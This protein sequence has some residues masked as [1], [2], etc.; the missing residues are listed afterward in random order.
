M[1]KKK[2]SKTPTQADENEQN[3][4]KGDSRCDVCVIEE[5]DGESVD[6]ATDN[7]DS[8]CKRGRDADDNMAQQAEISSSTNID[9]DI[10]RSTQ[11]NIKSYI[12]AETEQSNW[13]DC[14][15][16]RDTGASNSVVS[17]VIVHEESSHD[18]AEQ[19]SGQCDPSW[20]VEVATEA[21]EGP[22]HI[23]QITVD[24]HTGQLDMIT[25]GSEDELYGH[26]DMETPDKLK[27]VSSDKVHEVNTDG[28]EL[29]KTSPIQLDPARS[30]EDVNSGLSES[31]S[32]VFKSP[33]VSRTDV[34]KSLPDNSPVFS[35]STPLGKTRDINFG[36]K[37]DS[38][39]SPQP[40]SSHKV[41]S[42]SV[43]NRVRQRRSSRKSNKNENLSK[44]EDRDGIDNVSQ[45]GHLRENLE[46]SY[47]DGSES[48]GETGDS[49]E[50]MSQL[51]QHI[52]WY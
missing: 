2:A 20:P 6:I 36:L 27:V 28:D 23:V 16:S 35:K 43:K 21:E 34:I 9:E 8:K 1:Q 41:N 50:M 7:S 48:E 11:E 33:T 26:F 37:F 22:P 5:S 52:G 40:S 10:N 15:A 14:P 12:N 25:V 18:M 30:S 24:T 4:E 49:I 51:S 42:S 45:S 44:C 47:I 31:P 39:S 46:R 38:P 29:D 3:T 17:H 19:T 32:N 13:S